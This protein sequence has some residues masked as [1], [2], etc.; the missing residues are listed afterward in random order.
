[1]IDI[2]LIDDALVARVEMQIQV[3][4]LVEA[5]AAFPTRPLSGSVPL[6]GILSGGKDITER[7]QGALQ[8]KFHLNM[9]YFIL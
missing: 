3:L 9:K 5:L 1:M 7:M 2:Y 8:G 4:L 6:L